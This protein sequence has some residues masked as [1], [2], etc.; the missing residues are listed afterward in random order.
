MY[1]VSEGLAEIIDGDHRTLRMYI[2]N[3]ETNIVYAGD[4]IFTAESSQQNT[5]R[6]DDIEVGAICSCTWTVKMLKTEENWLGRK[7][8]L[9][10][11]LIDPEH[12]YTTYGDLKKYTWGE[13]S[14]MTIS[15]VSH[16]GEI[17]YS[18]LIPLG[19]FTAV[20]VKNTADQT[21]VTFADRL[22]FSDVKYS[23][24]GQLSSGYASEFEEDCCRIL[25]IKY[26]G[27]RQ[28]KR[29]CDKD[30]IPLL[31]KDGK[32]L[33]AGNYDFYISAIPT[34]CTIRQ[35]LS[36]IASAQG[37]NGFVD[38]FGTYQRVFFTDT[39]YELSDDKIDVPTLSENENE[40]VGISCKVSENLTLSTG[41]ITGETGR[42]IEF[43]NPYFKE[44]LL[45]F[46]WRQIGGFKWYTAEVSQRL[47]D[48]RLD[49][50]DVLKYN[51]KS[52][53]IT[54]LDFSFDGGLS[55]K[56]K[57]VGRNDLEQEVSV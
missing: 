34:D 36:Y 4:E 51:E 10:I 18:E 13:L 38:R 57:A 31:D 32:A 5:S 16:L 52:V 7:Y 22:Y 2:K 54:S 19:E 9:Y 8:E 48:P 26:S 44:S 37:Q 43:E 14:E 17:L 55:A 30:G 47:G 29:L 41:D 42:V 40:I 45:G 50:S 46:L 12:P 39:N 27:F 25:K 33:Y 21:E 23:T 15:Q 24:G 1:E 3:P 6:S 20:K 53:P 35:L 11:Y 56:I 49:I 28:A